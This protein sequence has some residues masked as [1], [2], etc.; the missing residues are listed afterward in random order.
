ML[1]KLRER[2]LKNYIRD[3]QLDRYVA[4]SVI[5]AEQAEALKTEKNG[6]LAYESAGGGM[7]L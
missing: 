7:S 1:D 6:T 5:T 3:D 4:L 2:Y